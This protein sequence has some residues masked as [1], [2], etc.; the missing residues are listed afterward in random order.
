[1]PILFLLLLIIIILWDFDIQT[2][3]L[4][5]TR[6]P[7]LIV[8]TPKSSSAFNNLSVT[9][10]KAPITIGIIVTFMLHIF[11]NS[12]AKSR[13]LSFFSHS[14]SFILWSAGTANSTNLQNLFFRWLLLGLIFWPRLGDLSVCQSPKGVC[15]CHSL[16]QMLG[17]AYTICSYGQIWIS[18]TSPSGSPCPTSR[19]ESYTHSV[20]ICCICLLCDW[21]FHLC[22]CIDYICYFV[23]SYLFSLWYGW[24]LWRCFVL[25]LRVILFLSEC[26]L[27]FTYRIFVN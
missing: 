26:F 12:L 25:L 4:N 20:I 6:R 27:F 11:F 23:A 1:M 5:S 7:D 19:I 14:F 9:V 21:W 10:S 2:D 3:H 22:H 15:V 13:Y 17:F 16:G 24:F 8:I 18:C